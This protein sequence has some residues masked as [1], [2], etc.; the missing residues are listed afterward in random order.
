MM[1][2]KFCHPKNHLKLDALCREVN[3]YIH[4][5]EVTSGSVCCVEYVSHM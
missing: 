3:S 4:R 5:F 1:N 2:L